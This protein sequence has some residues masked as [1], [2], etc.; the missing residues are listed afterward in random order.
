[1]EKLDFN[2]ALKN[3]IKQELKGSNPIPDILGFLHIKSIYGNDFSK[4]L[5]EMLQSNIRN[6]DK[7][8]RLPLLKIDVPKSNFTIRPMARPNIIEWLFYEAIINYFSKL[9]NKGGEQKA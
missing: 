5:N 6:L 9:I 1:M 3:I 4:I 8:K 2:F 7:L